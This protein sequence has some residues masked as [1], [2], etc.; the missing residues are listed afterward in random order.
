[1]ATQ[2]V[3]ALEIVNAAVKERL[4]KAESSDRDPWIFKLRIGNW[5]PL[6][7][8]VSRWNERKVQRAFDRDYYLKHY[9]DVANAGVEPLKHFLETGW[10]EGRNPT[11]YFRTSFYAATYP[12]VQAA[13]TN[14]F[15]H[16]ILEGRQRGLRPNE[17]TPEAERGLILDHAT[18]VPLFNGKPLAEKPARILAF[19]L[20][21]FHAIPENN[22]WW[23]EGFTEWTNVKAAVP[24][25]R[26]HYQPHVPGELGYYNLL[27]TSVQAR[28][29]ELAKLYGI[30]GFC[31][32]FYW[33]AGKRL[34]EK[35]VENWLNDK[36]LDLPF[37]LCWANENW[38]RRWDG[39][40]SEI[41]IAQNHSAEDDI[42]FIKAVAPYLRDQRYVRVDGKPLLIVYR[43]SLLPNMKKTATRWRDWC[44]RN[45][46]G[47]LHLAYTQSFEESDPSI[48]GL[49]AAIEFPPVR[50]Q[51]KRI[52]GGVRPL[53][54]DFGM[55][56]FDWREFK[57]RSDNYQD[58]G[59]V[60]YRGVC[61]NWDNT[62]RRKSAG[63]MYANSSPDLFKAWLINALK[64]T[65][66]RFSTNSERLLFVNAWNEWAEGA[67]LEPDKRYGYAWLQATRDALEVESS[68][69]RTRR[70]VIV[71]H[72]A[73]PH[74]AQFLALHLAQA[75]KGLG[76]GVDLILLGGGVLMSRFAEYATVHPIDIRTAPST[77]IARLLSSLAASGASLAL[78]NTVV[79]GALVP[80]LHEAGFRTVSLV[81]E[82]PGVLQGYGLQEASRF[83]ADFSDKVV[84]AAPQIKDG[85]E[86]FIGRELQQ[87]VIRPQGHY[88]RADISSDVRANARISIRKKHNLPS[89]AQI[90]LSVGYGDHR[91]GLDLFVETCIRVLRLKPEAAAIWVGHF[92]DTL[93]QSVQKKIAAEALEHRFIFTGFVEKPIDYYASADVYALT[94]REDPFPSVVLASL[95]AQVP[96]VAF[97]GAGGIGELLSK[98]CGVLVSLENCE[99][100]ASAICDMFDSPDYAES[101]GINGK[102]IVDEEF[103]FR[104]YVFDLLSFAGLAFPKISVVVPNFNYAHYLPQ[105]LDS[106]ARQTLASYEIIILDD[107]STDDSLE[108]IEAFKLKCQVPVKVIKNV[109]NSG[110]VFSQWK[111]G[112]KQA[113]GDFVWIAEADDLCDFTMLERLIPA[114]NRTDVVMSYCQSKQIDENGTVLCDNYLD[115]VS[116]IDRERW[117]TSFVADG[118][119]EVS[120]SLY[121]KNT[122]P[123]VSAVV[124]RR[125]ALLNVLVEFDEEIER[126][127]FAGDWM[128]YIRLLE[129]GA[130]SFTCESLN[131][132]RRHSNSV[133]ISN[134]SAALLR[135]ISHVQSDTIRR[136]KLGLAAKE[137]ADRYTQT[138][139]EQF[140]LGNT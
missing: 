129:R 107:A 52:G 95:E 47:E 26:G 50:P 43:P 28:Q 62:A 104:D 71:S 61:T 17:G 116:D 140:G 96:V 74:G 58:P 4:E 123:N 131:S 102:R 82:L 105:R 36:T 25:F 30:E 119:D 22:L 24:Q 83:I 21:Q 113:Q 118:P 46:V 38:S 94:S 91:K 111:R 20:P 128:T 45:G 16:Y 27:D 101:L 29:I 9:P 14:P 109:S 39:H 85:F 108:I 115:Y 12:E 133:T 90:V 51:V 88:H 56:L 49:D 77:D 7:T 134:H 18:P 37:C 40:D 33:F 63:T 135:E 100:M 64:D 2:E 48:Y 6:R 13:G 23:G 99:E 15:V 8:I 97:D 78:V 32:Y 103:D 42:E 66:K 41:L 120:K 76:I 79:S 86:R 65:T 92:D 125:E 139:F 122:I 19:Y 84:F 67:H 1:M 126:L 35:P 55:N 89:N 112:V 75:I 81:H 59:Y 93:M 136:F 3:E 70:V 31:F 57:E 68:Y 106:I 53:V 130:V 11:P 10:R 87:S 114:F 73:H 124:F 60:L 110:S 69:N 121:V 137:R 34:L 80:A 127:R 54:R 138:L 98:K 44:R 5:W 132:H 117:K 72:D